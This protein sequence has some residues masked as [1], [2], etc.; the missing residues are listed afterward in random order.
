MAQI[1]RDRRK[2]GD[3]CQSTEADRCDDSQVGDG[4]R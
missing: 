2:A 4:Y 1:L 3:E